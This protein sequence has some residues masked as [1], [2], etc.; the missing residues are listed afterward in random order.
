[1]FDCVADQLT[2]FEANYPEMMRAVYVIN[3]PKVFSIA[4]SMV[5]G[6]LHEETQKKVRIFGETGWKEVLRED[7]EPSLLPKYWGGNRVDP[8]GDE[9]CP[10]VVKLG[11]KIPESYYLKT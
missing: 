7:I 8:D 11:G 1:M 3:A 9:R 2:I 4:Y 6:F 10:S 5:K